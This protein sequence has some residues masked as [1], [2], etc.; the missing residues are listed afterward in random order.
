M[1]DWMS[2]MTR[3]KRADELQIKPLDVTTPL[4]S[5]AKAADPRVEEF[6]ARLRTKAEAIDN[7]QRENHVTLKEP[8]RRAIVEQAANPDWYSPTAPQ[9]AAPN[10]SPV[11]RFASS[12]GRKAKTG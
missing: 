1:S 5:E 2:N 10:A 8:R 9:K 7:I 3:S 12:P 11:K 6:L 4:T